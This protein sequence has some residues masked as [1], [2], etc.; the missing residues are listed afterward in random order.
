MAL[1]VPLIFLL[2]M[3]FFWRRARTLLLVLALIIS[4]GET[5]YVLYKQESS[6]EA[7]YGY[8]ASVNAYLE[9]MYPE[10]EWVSRQAT[11]NALFGAGVEVIFI[12]EPKVAYL[13]IVEEDGVQLAGYSTEDDNENPKRNE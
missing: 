13:Y 9:N 3:A 5:Y 10:D 8:E 2:I 6:L 12:D 7:W 4:L 1:V 11:R